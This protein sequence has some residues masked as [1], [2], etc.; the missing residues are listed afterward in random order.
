MVSPPIPQ[1]KSTIFI[2][3]LRFKRIYPRFFPQLHASMYGIY[4]IQSI[5]FTAYSPSQKQKAMRLKFRYVMQFFL[6]LRAYAAH[7][8]SIQD[9]R[10]AIADSR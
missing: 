1:N 8:R 3:L 5:K 10:G 2:D 7:E 9:L 6:I 4:V